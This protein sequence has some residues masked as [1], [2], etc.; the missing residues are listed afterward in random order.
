MVRLSKSLRGNNESF[1][2]FLESLCDGGGGKEGDEGAL[3]QIVDTAALHVFM[4]R[5]LF[6]SADF[7]AAFSALKL[8]M[9]RSI[10]MNMDTISLFLSICELSNNAHLMHDV[11]GRLHSTLGSK[12]SGN[13][14]ILRCLL[15]VYA[16]HGRWEW[17]DD[18]VQSALDD[19][20]TALL[21]Q[22]VA[23]WIDILV[24][25]KRAGDRTEVQSQRRRR[26][27][28]NEETEA[29]ATRTK[30]RVRVNEHFVSDLVVT[31]LDGKKEDEAVHKV[32]TEMFAEYQR[33]LTEAVAKMNVVQ[34]LIDRSTNSGMLQRWDQLVLKLQKS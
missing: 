3:G 24:L 5:V 34:A 26:R 8:M 15:R 32:L 19:G 2:D 14:R 31:V 1:I 12:M 4:E 10:L 23:E 11:H 25:L 29:V 6:P 33:Y 16:K 17:V 13:P 30:E 27:G 9:R 28:D 22:C 21:G 20:G 7:V 18:A